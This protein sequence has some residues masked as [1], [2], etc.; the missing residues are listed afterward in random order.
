ME[1]I[2]EQ[3]WKR[4]RFTSYFYQSVHLSAES[5][6]PTLALTIVQSR[7]TLFYNPEFI[8]ELDDE[9]I[10]GLMVHEMMHVMMNHDHRSRGDEDAVLQN[11]AQDMVVNNFIRSNERTFFSRKGQYQWDV[12]RLLLPEGL[13]GIPTRFF[14][15]T[16]NQD[17]SWEDVYMWLRESGE[18][19]TLHISG[20]M[21]RRSDAPSAM[22]ATMDS[23]NFEPGSSA[24]KGKKEDAANRT[25]DAPDFSG[26]TFHD[27]DEN[28]LPTGMHLFQKG[29]MQHQVQARRT[30]VIRFAEK[31]HSCLEERAFQDIQG[32]IRKAEPVDIDDWK[33]RIKSIVDMASQS[34]EWYYSHG[35][36]NRRYFASGIY[37]PGRVFEEKQVLTVAVDVSASMV[38]KPEEI[39]EA[40][41]VIEELTGKYRI[42]LLCIDE[43]LFVPEKS[44]DVFV[45]SGNVDSPYYY[46][47]G[48]WKYLRSGNSGTT[49]F[50]PLF[51]DYM[52][53]HRE[54]LLVITDGY[55]YDLDRLTRY[56]H[57][58]W[59][60]S[61]HRP[62]PFVPPFGRM[63]TIRTAETGRGYQ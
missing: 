28:S 45:K 63:V 30:Q 13:P 15:E 62:E 35:R 9:E 57:T 11:T 50:E 36:F 60:I 51:N 19:D 6:I 49:F 38:M 3:I 7:L 1:D 34:S 39:E 25:D 52:K 43:D 55:V 32:I 58:L 59:V 41:G 20:K 27:D 33:R 46:K 26:I 40:F 2:L 47:P 22:N 54:M 53:G 17:P 5:S 4:S 61:G 16:G 14:N 12:P 10:I 31:D 18:K 44:G 56:P 23:E 37:A 29:R 21:D 42:N 8:E 48:D 24:E